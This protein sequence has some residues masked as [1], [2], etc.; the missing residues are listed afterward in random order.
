[1][2]DRKKAKFHLDRG[3]SPWMGREGIVVRGASRQMT[4]YNFL[5][6]LLDVRWTEYA[7]VAGL[8][9]WEDPAPINLWCDIRQNCERQKKSGTMTLMS[10]SV[11]YWFAKDRCICPEEALIHQG[12]T[13]TFQTEE[14][15]KP[16][17][18][19]PEYLLPMKSK[20]R[21]PIKRRGCCDADS[22]QP[23]QKKAR[24]VNR[25]P[26]VGTALVDLAGNAMAL[27]DL[28]ILK[29]GLYLSGDNDLFENPP[30]THFGDLLNVGSASVELDPRRRWV[31]GELERTMGIDEGEA[32][33]TSCDDS[34][35]IAD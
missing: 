32:A 16:V 22:A 12:W 33:E 29:Y 30:Y 34:A 21:L 15:T 13:D 28:A 35:D 2:T 19:W 14:L 27:P 6:T 9:R 17:P 31:Q 8:N 23:V 11:P 5:Y 25:C 24:A 3:E 1:M 20:K 7:H 18:N 4:P 10:K 26:A